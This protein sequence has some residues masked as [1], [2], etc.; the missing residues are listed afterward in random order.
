MKFLLARACSVCVVLLV[1]C[2]W[3]YASTESTP[4]MQPRGELTLAVAIQT[5]LN[6]NPD[7][8]A[9]SYEITAAQARLIQA[10][11]RPNPE[12]T[13]DLE[14]FAGGG[15]FNGV[16]RLETTLSLSQ[17][18]ELGGKRTLRQS[19]GEANVDLAAIEQRARELDV[20]AEVARRFIDVVAAQQRV[21]VSRESVELAQKTLDAIAARVNAARS[22]EAE[23][24]RAGIALTRARL[25]EQ[26]AQAELRT[27]RY[28]LAATLGDAEPGFTAATADL[29][30][31][32]ALAS[33]AALAG[34]IERSPDFLR[35]ASESRLWDAELRLAQAQARPNLALSLG[36]RR[37]EE[38]SDAALVAG[39]SMPLPTSD[40]NQGTIREVRTRV[41][42]SQAQ[43]EA[44]LAR[45]RATLHGV[46]QQLLTSRTQTETL[47]NDAIPQAR[48]ALEQVQYGYER[49]RFSFLELADTQ[50]E[51]LGL[52]E[53]AITA[54]ADYHRLRADI[55]R[56]T[57][58]PLATT[59]HE[60]SLP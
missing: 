25:D 49:G 37:F 45:A 36:V 43:R 59:D 51:L 31:F 26:Q 42:Q 17:V 44:A 57:S 8:R 4:A 30:S 38:T 27:S 20:L 15:D 60:A 46:Y 41:L 2:G 32:Q 58:A 56:L 48:K 5:A 39:F 40:R 13:V 24:S 54:A 12:L 16:D 14:N 50:Q 3:A 28:S 21:Q 47:R 11:L 29:F 9:S 10:G 53:A 19:V 1:A 23:R 33:F 34:Q 18:I 55:E 52:Q 22:P 35:F 7:L 6:R